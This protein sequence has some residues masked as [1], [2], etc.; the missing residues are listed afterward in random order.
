M[1]ELIIYPS[2]FFAIKKIDEDLSEEYNAVKATG[3]FDTI[4]FGYDK[5]FN[6]GKL[7]LS[8]SV[9][10]KRKAIYRGWMMKPEQYESF[11]EILLENN[12][13]LITSP[14]EYQKM[15]VFSNVYQEFGNDTAKLMIFELHEPIDVNLLKR[16]FDRFMVKDFVKSVKGTSFPVFFQGSVS[17][18][19]FDDWM[20]VFYQYRGELL[21]GGICIKEY[22]DLQKYED[23]TNEYR[24]F[25]ANGQILTISKNSRQPDYAPSVPLELVEKYQYLASPYY[26][27]DF[28]ELENKEW[29]VLEAGDGGVS[30]IPE[31]EDIEAYYRALYCCFQ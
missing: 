2:S 24:V 10:G 31:N 4:L 5:W 15:H 14:K 6:D 28:A 16:N 21:T 8:N 17:Q 18:K 3:L 23:R 30:G 20:E 19:E 7:V 22:L 29:K 25:Y 11:Y 26:T 27:V 13:E 12:I 9:E 1:I